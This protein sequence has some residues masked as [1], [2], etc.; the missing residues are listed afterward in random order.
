MDIPA[1]AT[2]GA[3]R[4]T[5]QVV[6]SHKRPLIELYFQFHNDYGPEISAP[7]IGATKETKHRFQNIFVSYWAANI[8]SIR[9]EDAAFAFEGK[10]EPEWKMGERFKTRYPQLAPG[11]IIFLFSLDQFDLWSKDTAV[12]FSLRAEYNAPNRGFNRLLRL[13][14]S[15]RGRHQYS[16]QFKFSAGMVAGELPPPKYAANP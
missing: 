12:E 15:L 16:T 8:G 4:A 13:P 7:G 1:G 9:A 11:Q 10:I 6:A 3:L 2:V 5:V 14:S